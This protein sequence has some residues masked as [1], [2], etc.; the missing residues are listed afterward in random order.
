[1]TMATGQEAFVVSAGVQE[2]WA[3]EAEVRES[4]WIMAVDTLTRAARS[5]RT[6]AGGQVEPVD[7]A[8]FLASALGAVAGNLGDVDLVTAG[9]PGSW[10]SDLVDQL[11]RGTVGFGQELLL[12]HRTDPLVVPLNVAELVEDTGCLP[13]FF[14]AE[15]ELPFSLELD[16]HT[17]DTAWERLRSR[18]L[19]AYDAYATKFTEAVHAHALTLEGLAVPAADGGEPS[20]RVPVE[21]KVETE[22]D[23][24]W[25]AV[26]NP[27]EWAGDP[28]VWQLWQHA[29]E[30]AG[31][32]TLDSDVPVPPEGA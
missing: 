26:E 25:G 21:V 19:D 20:L 5:S 29:V 23:R 18:Y 10:E 13:S 27:S 28:I 2:A 30:T 15:A 12:A 1:M 17:Q 6:L 7:F 22:P 11:V 9:R 8:G 31:F 3:H 14:D 4:L 24:S 16:E 32:P